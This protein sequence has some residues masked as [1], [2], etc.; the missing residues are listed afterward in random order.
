[1]SEGSIAAIPKKRAAVAVVAVAT[2]LCFAIPVRAEPQVDNL[3]DQEFAAY[4]ISQGVEI[5]GSP[6]QIGNYARALCID[7][8]RLGMNYNQVL[9]RVEQDYP[10]LSPASMRVLIVT[11]TKTYCMYGTPQT[12]QYQ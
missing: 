9:T 7:Q 10:N 5:D 6:Q 12:E 4:L 8:Y 2:A 3:L 11:A 1:L